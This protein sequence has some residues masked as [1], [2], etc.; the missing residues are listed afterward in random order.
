MKLNALEKTEWSLGTLAAGRFSGRHRQR[1]RAG[2]RGRWELDQH[3]AAPL[4][5]RRQRVGA[6][7]EHGLY[8]R[9]GA[10]VPP[11][12]SAPRRG[13]QVLSRRWDTLLAGTRCTGDQRQVFEL[14]ERSWS[15]TTSVG[16]LL[17]HVAH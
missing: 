14:G 2:H 5:D 10:L 8:Q 11:L 12:Q 15:R 1:G 16:T 6:C 3:D 9:L 4:C 7:S 13:Q 17:G